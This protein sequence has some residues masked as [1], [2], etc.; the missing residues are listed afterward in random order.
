MGIEEKD[1][2]AE[3]REIRVLHIYAHRLVYSEDWISN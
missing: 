3:G 2:K 1:L